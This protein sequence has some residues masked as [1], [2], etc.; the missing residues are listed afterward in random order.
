MNFHQLNESIKKILNEEIVIYSGVGKHKV[1][2]KFPDG[3][4]KEE[5]VNLYVKAQGSAM[6]DKNI[7]GVEPQLAVGG[8][9]TD[10]EYD[11][12]EDDVEIEDEEWDRLDLP[13]G[14]VVDTILSVEDYIDWD[15]DDIYREEPEYEP[16]EDY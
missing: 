15:I 3:T 8:W 11:Y 10:D 5:I 9:V 7:Y 14:T 12:D 16:D 4:K 13:E 6:Y 1:I 2:L